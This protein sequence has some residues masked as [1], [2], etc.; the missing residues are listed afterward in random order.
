ML[1]LSG[2][3]VVE[4][5]SWSAAALIVAVASVLNDCEGSKFDRELAKFITRSA[6]AVKVIISPTPST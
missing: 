4:T 2:L 3:F 5:V 6:T 1:L